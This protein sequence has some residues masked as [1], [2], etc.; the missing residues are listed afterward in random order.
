VSSEGIS[1]GVFW[2][3]P[4]VVCVSLLQAAGSFW[5]SFFFLYAIAVL[6]AVFE[7]ITCILLSKVEADGREVEIFV[8][9]C[10]GG[11]DICE[12]SCSEK[13]KRQKTWDQSMMFM[14]LP[15]Q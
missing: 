14:G 8:T 10:S 13:E 9:Y 15:C 6:K 12:L 2:A 1:S 11:A 5:A 4:V 7:Q 3:I